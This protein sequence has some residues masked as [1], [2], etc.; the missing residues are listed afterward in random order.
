M[1]RT[2]DIL[3]KNTEDAVLNAKMILSGTMH[4]SSFTKFRIF[5]NSVV[6]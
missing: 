5:S 2:L 4:N 6:T 1:F 3:L